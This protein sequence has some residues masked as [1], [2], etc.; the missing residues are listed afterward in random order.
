MTQR[1][2][3][4]G[5]GLF[6]SGH[7]YRVEHGK[8]AEVGPP[9]AAQL[10][11]MLFRAA[12]FLAAFFFAGALR[13]ADFLAVAFAPF[14]LNARSRGAFLTAR[15]FG[16]T[17]CRPCGQEIDRLLERRRLGRRILGQRRIRLAI[18]D[19]RTITSFEELNLLTRH[20]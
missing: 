8:M 20:R 17:F 9:C 19:V 3:T 18:G 4:D 12:V 14:F 10:S 13:V 11:T 15:S 2:E 5:K 1:T 7:T 16:R 6:V